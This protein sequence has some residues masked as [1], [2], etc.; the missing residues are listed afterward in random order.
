[1]TVIDGGADADERCVLVDLV[2]SLMLND[3]HDETHWN[4]GLLIVRCDFDRNFEA[5]AA[6]A[7]ADG[8]VE[9]V[10]D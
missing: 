6:A 8:P 2:W 3:C 5:V 1:M 7:A 4:D 10:H 9:R